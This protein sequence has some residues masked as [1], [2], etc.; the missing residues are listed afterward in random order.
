M[1]TD[2][3]KRLIIL[4]VAAVLIALILT[5]GAVSCQYIVGPNGTAL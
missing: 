3:T 4:T 1:I 2:E 5:I